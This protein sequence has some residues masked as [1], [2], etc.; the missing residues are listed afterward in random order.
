[1]ED[2]ILARAALALFSILAMT[3]CGT[4]SELAV[5]NVWTRDTIG[6]TANAAVF[7]T[8]QSGTPDRLVAASSPAAERTDLMTMVED[9]GGM[10]MRFVEAIDIPAGVPVS[11][12]PAGL[13]VWLAKLEQPLRA[14]QTF[15]LLLQF[16]R[17]GERKVNVAVIAPS[18]APPG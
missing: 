4:S 2:K 8:I 16:D 5:E 14:G 6:R 7:M 1:M 15:P 17:A 9:G 12:D 13:H 11:L 3:S 18:A 10:K